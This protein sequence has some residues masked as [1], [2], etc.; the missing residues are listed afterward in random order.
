MKLTT[1]L[2]IVTIIQVSAAGYAQK[3]TFKQKNANIN[4]VFD[5]IK[6][7]TGYDVF[8]LPKILNTNETISAN[9]NNASLDE[10]MKICLQ[11]QHVKYT[12]DERTIVI[13]KLANENISAPNTS[14]LSAIDIKGKVVD[15]KG[16]PLPGAN[17]NV[18]GKNLR[19]STNTQ[20]EFTLKNVTEDDI[21][22]I[23]FLGF[24]T[25][26]IKAN[27]NI[28]TIILNQGNSNLEEVVVQ[29]YGTTKKRALTNS[30]STISAKEIDSRQISNINTALVGAAPGIQTT[31][32]SGQPGAGPS[33][34]I[35]GFGSINGGVD[36][37]YVV[38]GAPF[39]GALNQINP[40][41]I[42]TISVLKDASATALY[43]SRASNGIVLITTKKGKKG[44]PVLTA[45]VTQGLSTR[46]LQDY[47]S[48]ALTI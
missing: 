43:G 47:E 38:D 28:G 36:P 31:T 2:I 16:L 24:Q 39:D 5:E 18:K 14:Q 25:R 9:F 45:K 8:Y 23:S 3:L 44:E 12:I 29:A 33:I 13:T 22:V 4:Q 19:T 6:K 32:G 10:V 41:D 21:L 17:I 35:R 1:L 46:G 30:V 48:C 40:D 34:R 15:E 20:G 26:E 42:E 37:L 11:N 7:Q 27:A